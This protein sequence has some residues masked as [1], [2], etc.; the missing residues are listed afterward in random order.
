MVVSV[1]EHSGHAGIAAWV[2]TY[3]RL[4]DSDKIDKKD[5]R[6]QVIKEWVD[7]EY[8]SGRNT[9]MKSEELEL[10]AKNVI[11]QL[12]VRSQKITAC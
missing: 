8:M 3:F 1:N 10:I 5:D 7:K 4:K 12:R 2:N 9:V 6:I 11:P